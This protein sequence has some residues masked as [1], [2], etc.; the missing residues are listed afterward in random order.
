MTED[1]LFDVP[2]T[3]TER[4]QFVL[5][6][7]RRSEDGLHTDEIGALLHERSGKHPS[8]ARCDW[9]ATD[10]NRMLREL[11]KKRLVTRRMTGYVNVT[12][13][14]REASDERDLG[15]ATTAS[16]EPLS[17]QPGTWD[18]STAPIPF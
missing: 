3:L 12:S 4:Q 6:E 2:P 9:C 17:R 5:D 11:R 16:P 1:R 18:P 15:A 13:V 10:G 7:I 14:G 8:S